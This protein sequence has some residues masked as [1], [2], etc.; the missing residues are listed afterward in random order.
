MTG[1][2]YDLVL[3]IVLIWCVIGLLDYYK[4]LKEYDSKEIDSFRYGPFAWIW[5]LL[6]NIEWQNIVEKDKKGKRKDD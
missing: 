3:T 5:C 2:F 4:K 6:T 1:G